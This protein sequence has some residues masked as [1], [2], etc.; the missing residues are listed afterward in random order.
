MQ[1]EKEKMLSGKPYNAFGEELVSERRR[2]AELLYEY[3]RLLPGKSDERKEILKKLLGSTCETFVLEPP[4]R[5]DYGYNIHLGEN[6]F[7]NYNLVILDC[8]RV[9]IGKNALIGP[10]VGIYTA[11]HPVHPEPR[12]RDLEYALPVTIGDNVWIGGRVI[13]NP[14]ITISDN[15]VIG[16]GSVVTKDIPSNVIALGNPCQVLR[17]INERDRDYYYKNLRFDEG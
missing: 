15:A 1:S 14:G 11:G 2:A 3:N 6:F 4:F 13:I 10:D 16:S 5:C 12:T 9:S 7:A 17:Q 8:A